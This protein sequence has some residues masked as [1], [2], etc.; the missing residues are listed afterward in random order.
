GDSF[1]VA[2]ASAVDALACAV[3]AQRVLAAHPWPAETGPLPVRMALHTADV[4]PA[5]G[6]YHGPAI[7]YAHRL[8][9][10][11]HGGQILCSEVAAGLLRRGSLHAAE[12]G[13]WLADLGP[14]RLR[15]IPEAERLFQVQYQDMPRREFPQP[16]AQAGLASNLPLRLTRF[17]GRQE[18]I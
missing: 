15:D 1:M 16:A 5:E 17:F 13:I 7:N 2:F 14:Y 9:G 18:D 12:A 8:L 10:A 3:T 6:D 11:A 4:Q